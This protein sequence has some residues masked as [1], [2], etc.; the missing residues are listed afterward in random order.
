MLISLSLGFAGTA[1][2]AES[3]DGEDIRFQQLKARVEALRSQVAEAK[4]ENV[5]IEKEKDKSNVGRKLKLSGDVRIKAINQH[6]GKHTTI[7]ESVQLLG[8]YSFDKDW[9]VGAKYAFM[10]DNNMGTSTRNTAWQNFSYGDERYDDYNA[11]D[12]NVLM[13]LYVKKNNFLGNNSIQI[14]RMGPSVLATQYWSAQNS[15]G[16][17]DGIRLAF[18]KNEDLELWYGDWGAAATYSNYWNNPDGTANK[19]LLGSTKHKAL[20]K[21]IMVLGKYKLS[22][23]T[24]A[25]GFFLNELQ[26]KRAGDNNYKMRGIGFSTRYGDWRLAA[27]FTKNYANGAVGRFFRLRYKGSDRAVPGSWTIG[28]DYMK[29]EPGNLYASALNGVNDVSMGYKDTIGI[30]GFVLWG[31]YI[32]RRNLRVALYQSIGRKATTSNPE[33]DYDAY[34]EFHK[35]S[36]APQYSRIH[37]IWS[38]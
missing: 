17:Y 18:G 24:T 25:Y 6:I 12:N 22:P 16:L 30:D 11:A 5:K 19:A 21:N 7:T 37:F 32:L 8:H 14:G 10:S 38:F 28:L 33:K 31:D 2:A 23:V 13:N 15:S 4:N 36:S 3:Q 27:D 20:E 26:D 9:M 1:L 34:G 29:I 35:G